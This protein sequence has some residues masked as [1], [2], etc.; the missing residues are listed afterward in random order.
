MFRFN[1]DSPVRFVDPLPEAVDVIIIGGGVIGISAAWM[2]RARGL[3]VLV[4]E[5]GVVAGEQSSRNWGWVRSTGRDADEVPIAMT[6]TDIW[7]E[8]DRD[9][10]QEIGFRRAGIS[11]LA[12]T[13][14][15]LAA[16]ESWIEEVAKQYGLPS[17]ML[18]AAQANTLAG[19]PEGPW[20]G[21]IYTERDGRAEPFT[22]VPR[23][24]EALREREGL[25]REHC[26]ARVIEMQAGQVQAV[27]TEHGRVRCE[28]VICA[29]GGWSKLFLANLGIDLPQLV[30]RGTV[31]RTEAVPEFFSGA[32]AFEDICIRRRNDG[33]YTVAT[34]FCEHFIGPDSFRYLFKFLPSMKMATDIAVRLG[35]DATQK[36]IAAA[37]W[38]GDEVTPFERTRVNNPVAS[39]AALKKIRRKLAEHIPQLAQVEFAESWAGMIDATPD[40]VPVMDEIP[41]YKGLFLATGFSGHGFGIGPG[42]G[43]V[44]ADLVTGEDPGY[45]LSRFRFSRFTDGSKIRPG[46]AL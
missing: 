19:T 21:G 22:A 7:E 20:K 38:R 26:A 39:D 13:D 31:A 40:V 29:A 1:P 14:E 8:F 34:G 18:N 37:R 35:Q 32:G 4:C 24:A 46:P 2:L 16:Y 12:R 10:G 11:A 6:A 43:K 23:I 17:H 45:D 42:A 36:G 25:I 33:G 44:M 30:V 9:L 5:K 28:N 3:S 15:E 27:V 41:G